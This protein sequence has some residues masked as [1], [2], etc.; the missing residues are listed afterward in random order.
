MTKPS[1]SMQWVQWVPG[2]SGYLG[3]VGAGL[4]R[5]AACLIVGSRALAG[6]SAEPSRRLVFF[7]ITEMTFSLLKAASNAFTFD[8]LLRH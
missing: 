5:G 1:G 2:Y 8:T 6:A 7:S 3:T 4:R